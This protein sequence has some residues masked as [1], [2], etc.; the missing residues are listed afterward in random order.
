MQIDTCAKCHSR[1]YQVHEDFRPG[2]PLLDYYEPVLLSAG[3]YQADGQIL[4]EV[5]EYDSFLQSKMHANHVVC[6][7][8]HDPHSLKLK[9]TGNR[10]CEQCHLA[11]KFDT[12]AHHHHTVGSTGS[13][14]I[15]CHMASRMYMVIDER[16]DHS[17]RIPRPDLS[18]TLGTTNACN[19]CHTKPNETFAWAAAAIKKW[20]G[21]KK[22]TDPHWGPAFKAGRAAAR[23]ARNCCRADRAKLDTIGRAGDGNR[24]VGE[25]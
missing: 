8:C 12:P 11:A 1:R 6:S 25:L 14:C 15:Q 21:D 4:D 7:N 22:P 19:N 10:L 5:Y 17:F 3:L 9:F 18:A 20:Y 2:R 24:S 23:K 13:Q 16:R